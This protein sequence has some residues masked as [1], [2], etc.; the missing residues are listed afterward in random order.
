MTLAEHEACAGL[1][2]EALA[3]LEGALERR[4][5]DAG[6][7]V[8]RKGDPADALYLL[9]HGQVSVVMSLPSGEIKRLAMFPAGMAFGELAI[10]DRG[11]RT[12]DVRA[13]TK[14]ECYVL[15]VAALDRLGETHP[16]IK[17]KLLENLLRHV[18]RTVSRLN[19]EVGALSS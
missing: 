8:I 16:A 14:A 11:E 15:P 10:I 6:T 5:F 9:M 19:Q 12:A 3:V 4:S 7:L 18:S 1:S 17:M 13:D 2:P